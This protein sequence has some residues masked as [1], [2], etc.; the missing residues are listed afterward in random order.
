MKQP[1][2]KPRKIRSHMALVA[3]LEF[4]DLEQDYEYLLDE[5]DQQIIE[6]LRQQVGVVQ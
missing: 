1:K 6:R 2:K 3:C 5:T 4:C